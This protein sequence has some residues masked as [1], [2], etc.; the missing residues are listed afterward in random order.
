MIKQQWA[1]LLST[2]RTLFGLDLNHFA[3][4]ILILVTKN[5]L[6]YISY[7]IVGGQGV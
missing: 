1:K 2:N 7:N 5:I 6:N 4:Q 3:K